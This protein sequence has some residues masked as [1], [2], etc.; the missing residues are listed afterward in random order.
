[1]RL[2]APSLV[3][4]PNRNQ[5]AASFDELGRVIAIAI[6][7]K[8]PTEGDTLKDP[9]T[10]FDY[11]FYD[12]TTGQPSM[13]HMRAREQ[14]GAANKR[15]QES[16]SYSDGSGHEVMRKL[17][18]PPAPGG[19][20]PRWVGTGRTVFDNKGNPVKKYEPYF[21]PT[22]A[23]ED[24]PA[25][26]MQGVTPILHYDPLGRLVGIDL[27]NGTFSKVD[28]GPWQETHS[29]P[30]DTVLQS[31][32]YQDRQRPGTPASEQ[33]AASKAAVHA[34]TPSVVHLDPLG[35]TFLTIEDNGSAGKYPIRVA[36]DVEGNALAITDVRGVTVQ[37]AV[38]AMNQQLLNTTSCDAGQHWTLNDVMGQPFRWW[39]ARGNAVRTVFD[40]MR[41]PTQ[42]FVQPLASTTPGSPSPPPPQEMLAEVRVYGEGVAKPEASN[43][44]G[45]LYEVYD[46]AGAVKSSPYDF[47]GNL[48][49]TTRRV[50]LTYQAVPDWS[51]LAQLTDPAA[52]EQAAQPALDPDPA[53]VFTSSTTFDALNRATSQT[54][55][56]G[57]LT[58]PTYNEASQL[59]TLSVSL[60][61][62]GAAAPF[63]T[64]IQYNEKG[65]RLSIAY[66]NG[67]VTSYKYD[68]LTFRMSDLSTTRTSDKT[69]LQGLHY[70]YDPVGNIVEIDD[71]A[72]KEVYYNGALVT[73]T[74]RYTYD[75]IYR[76]VQATGRELAGGAGDGQRDQNDLPLF[77]TP[78]PND[79]QVV[80]VGR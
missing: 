80:S 14:H 32:W 44:R 74:A 28:F 46:G 5:V 55:P 71:A 78:H 59:K 47:K 21:S 33:D 63:V 8:D 22:S 1:M 75:A 77:N 3:T 35:R 11:A 62:G 57:S 30:N 24:E 7:G 12:A 79:V 43:L 19:T 48:L 40:T 50:T 41:R 18:A 10:T 25:I 15:W 65:Q 37:T 60:P 26:V 6:M 69:L 70:T 17:Q 36:L 51:A 16:Y 29:D 68:P 56:D 53:K 58:V 31:R 39:D 72:Q 49:T 61:G 73:S 20:A 42:L 38:F 13:V 34:N 54:A 76:L 9:T 64:D 66:A 27:P 45:K 52:I 23:Y 2:L 4:D 67:V